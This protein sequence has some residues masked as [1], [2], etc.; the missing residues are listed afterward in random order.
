MNRLALVIL[1]VL[2]L[3][4]F[5]L[6]APARIALAAS[7]IDGFDPG[8]NG[9]VTVLAVQADGKILVGGAFTMLGGGGTGTTARNYIGRLN[10]DGSLDTT[11]NPGANGQVTVL[12]V[13]ADGKIL[14]GGAFT[15]LGGGG[16]GTTARNYIGRLNADGS[17]DATFNPG[18][19]NQVTVLAVQAD[20]NILV[21]GAFTTLGGQ[22][23][24][25]IGRLNADGS[26]DTTFNPGANN[27]VYAM[28]VQADGKILVGGLFTTLGGQSRNRIGR[29]NA[30]GSVDATFNPGANGV[31]YV[32]AVQADGKI[33]V[34]GGFTTLGG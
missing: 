4:F 30:D 23:R 3:S 1:S 17:L 21:G 2:L 6:L 18:A 5:L 20:G 14:V 32:L 29:L 15:M 31:V 8:A 7:P 13:Q 10:T 33:L 34:G 24:N 12:A 9:Q 19:G 22:T 11:F 26:L 28:A 25:R 16:T 27:V